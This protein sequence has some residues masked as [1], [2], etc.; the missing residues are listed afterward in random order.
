M[1]FNPGK[2]F[3]NNATPFGDMPEKFK[4]K[5]FRISYVA[6]KKFRFILGP[7]HNDS[8]IVMTSR[9]DLPI[10]DASIY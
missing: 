3:N 2:P 9:C 10:P 8:Q 7:D 4:I 1:C 6:T 5:K